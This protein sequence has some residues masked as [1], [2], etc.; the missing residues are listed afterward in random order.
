[1]RLPGRALLRSVCAALLA[2]VAAAC[3]T[4]GMDR[5]ELVVSAASDLALAMPELAAAFDSV[6]GIRIVP[7]LGSTGQLA[8]Q[9][10]RG[11]PVDVFLSADRS[12]I[13]RLDSAGLVAP[14]GRSVYAYGRL[15]LHGPGAQSDDLTQLLEPSAG[16]VAI[17]NPEHAPYGRA[18]QQALRRAGVWDALQPRL[19]IAE[20]VR[21]ARQ[22]VDARTVD[23]AIVAW[24]LMTAADRYVLLPDALHDPLEQ[25][26]AVIAG[27]PD[28]AH[29]A[30]F[31]RFIVGTAG[32]SILARYNFILPDAP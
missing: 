32:R 29:A 13:E 30:T 6:H 9:I 1:V 17:A 11:A 16:R 7:N 26:L 23:V 2:S 15:V 24:S 14:A 10:L 20:N 3:G 28:T 27:R 19:V 4:S 21:Q 8:Q 31:A 12:W 25:T 18:A 5:T 22:L